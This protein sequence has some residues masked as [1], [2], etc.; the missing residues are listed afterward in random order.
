MA[1]ISSLVG[2]K[3]YISI[4]IIQV[5]KDLA[6]YIIISILLTAYG[7]VFTIELVDMT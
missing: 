2:R 7:K 3:I 5:A 4:C 6:L 1:A